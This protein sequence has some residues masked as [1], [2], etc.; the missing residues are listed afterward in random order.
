ML[1]RHPHDVRSQ[2]SGSEFLNGLLSRYQHLA[3]HVAALLRRSQLIFEMHATR[4]GFDHRL[5]QLEC[6]PHAAEAGFGI[7]NDRGEPVDVVRCHL[8]SGDWIWHTAWRHCA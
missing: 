8:P 3:A 4:T 1:Y 2:P 7:G 6:I 5:H